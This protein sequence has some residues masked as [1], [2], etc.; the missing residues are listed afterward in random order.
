MH[1]GNFNKDTKGCILPGAKFSDINNDGL[2]DVVFSGH[3]MN[4]LKA[5]LSKEFEIEII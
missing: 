5:L 3:T 2:L 4:D 1:T